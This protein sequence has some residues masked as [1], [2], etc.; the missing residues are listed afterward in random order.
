MR[1]RILWRLPLLLAAVLLCAAPVPCG[2]ASMNSDEYRISVDDAMEISVY[3]EP[4]LSTTVRVSQ[5]GTIN[6]PFLGNI[7]AV[8]L[9]P[10][11]LQSILTE[12]LGE[13]YLV[14]P[15][16]NVFITEYTKFAIL[17]AVKNPGSFELKEQMTASQAI[18]RAGGFTDVADASKVKII[19][20]GAQGKETFEVNIDRILKRQ[21]DDVAIIGKDTII[22][23]ELGRFS[24]MGQVVKPGMYT[25]KKDLTVVEA[26]GMAGGFTPTAAQNSIRLVRMLEGGTKRV[27]NVPVSEITKS[28]DHTKN[29]IVESGDTIIVPESFF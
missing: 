9:T 4:D 21:E 19:R 6:Y 29:L 1:Y 15:Q 24:I 14:N 27:F 2:A 25:L 5:D 28:G 3:G 10:R 16:V 18:V 17:G 7:Q 22:V 23:D 8:G 20:A 26:I 13:D 11:E 12:L